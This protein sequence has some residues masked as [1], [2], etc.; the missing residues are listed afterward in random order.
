M[1]Y[2]PRVYTPNSVKSLLKFDESATNSGVSTGSKIA[3]DTTGLSHP[4][5]TGSSGSLVIAGGEHVLVGSPYATIVPISSTT[6]TPLQFRW[7][8]VTNSQYIGVAGRRVL[9]FTNTTISTVRAPCAIAYVDS[10]I[11]VELRV[12]SMS[13]AGANAWNSYPVSYLGAS[14][15][16]IYSAIG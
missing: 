14:W 10:A 3:L 8:D 2:D 1:S 4:N 5:V 7:Y 9:K 6:E 16:Y 15:A 11:T 13:G 12:E